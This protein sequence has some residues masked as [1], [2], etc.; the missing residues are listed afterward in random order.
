MNMPQFP[1]REILRAA[2]LFCFRVTRRHSLVKALVYLIIYSKYGEF[3][4]K[5][6]K[7]IIPVVRRF[8]KGF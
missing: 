5:A 4:L 2:R 6:G 8:I 3:F 1:P 7:P